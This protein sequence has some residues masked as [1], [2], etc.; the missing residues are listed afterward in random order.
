MHK[1]GIAH[2]KRRETLA[3]EARRNMIRRADGNE[4]M[5]EEEYTPQVQVVYVVSMDSK[6]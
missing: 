5:Q 1:R 2:H 4:Q 3:Q 6:Q